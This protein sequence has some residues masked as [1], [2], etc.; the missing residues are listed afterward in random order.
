MADVDYSKFPACVRVC[1]LRQLLGH[2]KTS[3]AKLLGIPANRWSNIE[4]GYPISVDVADRLRKRIPGM[5]LDYLY[6]GDT[7]GLGE[8][9][10]LL[11]RA[12]SKSKGSLL[13][14]G[15]QFGRSPKLK[16]TVIPFERD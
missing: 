14:L 4:L 9:L 2:S 8:P 15:P 6:D 10:R 5:T 11:L 7:N 16:A 12:S 3:F 1:E 13:P